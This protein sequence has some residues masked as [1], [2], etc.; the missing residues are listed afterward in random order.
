MVTGGKSPFIGSD[1]KTKHYHK[2]E[3]LFPVANFTQF[4][5]KQTNNISKITQINTEHCSGT[6]TGKMKT[7]LWERSRPSM[8]KEALKEFSTVLPQS[9]KTRKGIRMVE[10]Q[11]RPRYSN[12]RP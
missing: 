7:C 6:H 12:F 8:V 11:Y 9:L 3:I 2:H 1:K 10:M 4:K 5:T